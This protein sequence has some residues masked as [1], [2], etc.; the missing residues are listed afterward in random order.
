MNLRNKDYHQEWIY[1][2]EKLYE[3]AR[4]EEDRIRVIPLSDFSV[5]EANMEKP[6]ERRKIE[7]AEIK[8]RIALEKEFDNYLRNKDYPQEWVYRNGKLYVR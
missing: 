3:L 7:E 4:K 1:K 8:N 6:R 5:F 2:D